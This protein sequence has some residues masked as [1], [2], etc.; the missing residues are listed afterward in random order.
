[1][2]HNPETPNS[3]AIRG[4][5]G[6]VRPLHGRM[7]LGTKL[8][9]ALGLATAVVAGGVLVGYGISQLRH[10][11]QQQAA[12]ELAKQAEAD[13]LQAAQLQAAEASQAAASQESSQQAA[14]PEGKIV[15]A[16]IASLKAIRSELD[17]TLAALKAKARSSA[18]ASDA[19]DRTW[20]SRQTSY[21]RRRAA[22]AS[23]N[24][25]ERRRFLGSKAEVSKNG[26]LVVRYT[27]HPRYLGSPGQPRKPG[28]LNVT[29]DSEKK[30]LSALQ[31][32]IGALTSA[33]GSEATSAAAF[34]SVYPVLD[35]TAKSLGTT[36]SSVRRMTG[37]AVV[38]KGAK[39]KV[40]DESKISAVSL[41]A[42]DASLAELDQAF[43]SAIAAAGLTP[44]QVATGSP[45]SP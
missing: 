4:M 8:L 9:I 45:S 40:I 18:S 22:V 5:S 7:S 29:L 14:I 31:N 16:H 27:Y 12:Q 21:S 25:S 23:H 15:S 1:V 6:K 3:G 44:D 17:S 26:Q 11:G 13:R 41:A 38:T 43:A 30:R 10:G 37:A 19:W 2:L 34:A 42:L 28:P 39:G 36:V 33:I 20:A 35:S 24:A 32:R